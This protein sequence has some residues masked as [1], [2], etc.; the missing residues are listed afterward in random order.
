[1]CVV[2]PLHRLTAVGHHEVCYMGPSD[3]ALKG[4]VGCAGYELAKNAMKNRDNAAQAAATQEFNGV[5]EQM[6]AK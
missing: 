2:C 6:V 4:D 5:E 1:M 3:G